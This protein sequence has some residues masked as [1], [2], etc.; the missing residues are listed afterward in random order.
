MALSLERITGAHVLRAPRGLTLLWIVLLSFCLIG[1]LKQSSIKKIYPVGWVSL[2]PLPG[3][4]NS[5]GSSLSPALK[6]QP[7]GALALP[8][9]VSLHY[10]H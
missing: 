7:I 8:W 6:Q 10:L 1:D 4:G 5:G 9:A 2:R 3:K